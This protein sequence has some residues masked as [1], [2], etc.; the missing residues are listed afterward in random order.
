MTTSC[1]LFTNF[2]LTLH[3]LLVNKLLTH[4]CKLLTSYRLI[5]IILWISYELLTCPLASFLW[6]SYR[7]LTN[8]LWDSFKLLTS[9]LIASFTLFMSVL[10]GTSY[11]FLANFLQ[12]LICS[13]QT[14]EVF[15][16]LWSFYKLMK[17][18]QTYEFF[19]N[20]LP[21]Y[22]KLSIPSYS[23]KRLMIFLQTS[24][25][26]LKSFLWTFQKLLIIISYTSYECL[27]N[28]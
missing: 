19:T 20:F 17:F 10:L 14:Y 13:L 25:K 3:I 11:E 24:Y 12:A 18:L 1:K 15:I 16:N 26:L 23:Y 5:D 6:T 9:F 22:Q 27:K 4:F 7:H 8:F 2:L 21:T 28:H